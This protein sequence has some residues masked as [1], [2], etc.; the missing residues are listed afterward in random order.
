MHVFSCE[1]NELICTGQGGVLHPLATRLPD[2][3]LETAHHGGLNVRLE[4]TFWSSLQSAIE[5]AQEGDKKGAFD[6]R[7][8]GLLKGA[9]ISGT[10]DTLSIYLKPHLKM[11][12]KIYVKM[13][14][15]VYFAI[16]R[17]TIVE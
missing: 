13:H 14:K 1:Q 17:M 3:S 7:L 11:Y 4:G 9:F 2:V 6:V 10:E 12:F 5:D 8:D 16:F 15:K